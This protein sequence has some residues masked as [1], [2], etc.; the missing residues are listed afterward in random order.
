MQERIARTVQGLKTYIVKKVSY[1]ESTL[2]KDEISLQ[3]SS[4]CNFPVCS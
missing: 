2:L 1:A 4:V 3:A